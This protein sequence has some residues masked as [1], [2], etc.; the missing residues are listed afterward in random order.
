MSISHSLANAVEEVQTLAHLACHALDNVYRD[1]VVVVPLDHGQEVTA[2]HFE[3]H[4]HVPPMRPHVVETVHQ[5]DGAAIRVQL[6]AARTIRVDSICENAVRD[7]F[8]CDGKAAPGVD[9]C[10]ILLKTKS[11]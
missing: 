2:Q 1:A 3:D 6:A 9:S 5:L 11:R 7:K 8:K 10:H 4:T